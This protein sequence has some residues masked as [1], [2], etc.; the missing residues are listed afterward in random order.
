ME[1]GTFQKSE[2]ERKELVEHTMLSVVRVIFYFSYVSVYMGL[3]YK[4]RFL[5]WK[6]FK[7][8]GATLHSDMTVS[9]S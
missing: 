4:I 2:T 9:N 8:H 1:T 6:Q 5:L 7:K 3:S